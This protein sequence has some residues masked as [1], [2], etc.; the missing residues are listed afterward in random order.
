MLFTNERPYQRLKIAGGNR[1]G[2]SA[3]LAQQC[4]QCI[5][6]EIAVVSIKHM[7]LSSESGF[8]G[9]FFKVGRR[10]CLLDIPFPLSNVVG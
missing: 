4:Q 9:W 8:T 3:P 7:L 6:L 10:C 2:M 5:A 1:L